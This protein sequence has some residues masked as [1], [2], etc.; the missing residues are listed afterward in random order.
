MGL[1]CGYCGKSGMVY[2]TRLGLFCPHC[3]KFQDG[4]PPPPKKAPIVKKPKDGKK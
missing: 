2:I 1:R 4:T 3:R